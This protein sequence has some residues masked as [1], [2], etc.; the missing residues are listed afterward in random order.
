[1]TEIGSI[2]KLLEQRL[3][4]FATHTADMIKKFEDRLTPAFQKVFAAPDRNIVWTS[5]DSLAGTDK[6][7]MVSGLM[8]F[9]LGDV[10]AVGETQ[11]TIDE[12]NITEYNKYVRFAFPI[13]MLELA[14]VDELWT[15]I[16]R[17]NKI[18]ASVEVTA[19]KLASMMD[20]C[21]DA[22]EK[23]VLENPEKIAILD[24]ATKPTSILGFVASDLTD[25][26]IRKLK[27]YENHELR[28]VN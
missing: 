5:I 10:V 8:A 18:G 16:T 9:R 11:V 28:T 24:A 4:T 21:A 19:E 22:Y 1:M 15:H 23:S 25:E 12:T 26:Q 7:V 3:N 2:S 14:S 27:L 13:I 6:A 17:M 20:K